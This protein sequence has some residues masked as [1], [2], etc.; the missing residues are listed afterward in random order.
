MLLKKIRLRKIGENKQAIQKLAGFL[1][2]LA[3]N[4]GKMFADF[5]EAS[6]IFGRTF[7]DSRDA[8]KFLKDL[9]VDISKIGQNE[10]KLIKSAK[11]PEEFVT[12]PRLRRVFETTHPDKFKELEK[13]YGYHKLKTTTV[14]AA[15][16]VG[17][18][19]LGKKL[20]LD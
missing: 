7:K 3:E 19:Y 1:S 5:G 17:A 12:N 13:L 6:R 2:E 18:A 14:K 4:A 11:T 16:Y 20:F 8:T 10:M 9:G 15:P